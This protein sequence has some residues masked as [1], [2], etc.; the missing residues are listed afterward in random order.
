VFLGRGGFARVFKAKRKQDGVYVAV[1][2]PMSLDE[3]TGKTFLKEI[4]NWTKL[5]HQNIVKVYDYNIM[6]IPFF[7]MELC[8][9]DLTTLKKPTDVEESVSIM[10]GVCQGLKY[11][12]S[13]RIIHS[14]LKPQNI[15]LKRGVPKISDW[16]LS[17]VVSDVAS[18]HSST[19]SLTPNYA[20]PEQ[21]SARFG[22]RNERTDIWQFGAVLYELVT[23]QLPFR[24]KDF[25]EIAAAITAEQPL[26]PSKLVPAALEIESTIMRCLDKQQDR[27]YKS[28]GEIE[29]DLSGYVAL[30]REESGRTMTVQRT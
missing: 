9:G 27:R 30:K 21:I 14:D 24:G 25:T 18:T 28:M 22:D 5:D 3:E 17:K 16:G 1:K 8:D 11:V 4:E 13:L 12:H 10:L 19:T 20:A 26:A 2:I 15:M 23:G 7:E 29:R 6:P